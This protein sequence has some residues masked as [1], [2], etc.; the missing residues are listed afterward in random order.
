MTI[1]DIIFQ[2]LHFRNLTVKNRIFRSNISGR[3]DNY[4]GS[5]SQARIN[6]EEK[7][8]KGGVGAI[9]SSFVPVSI[10]GRILPNYA[11]IHHD[12][13]I[14]FWRKL[15]E[16]L[17]EY[18]C[19]YI[20]QLSHSGRQQDYGGIENL[21]KKALSST[22]KT[23]SFHG[24]VCQAMTKAEIDEA[25]QEFADGA[26]RARQAGLD[27]V[28][29]HGANGYLITQFLSSGINDRKDEYGGSLENRARFLMEIIAAV[30]RE[31]G[32]D[33]HFQVKI[34]AVD[35]NNAVIPWE[36]KGNTLED[37][38]Q[39]CKWMEQAGVDAIHV[40]TGSLFPHP[41]NP[42]GGFPSDE[43][44]RTYDTIV[45]SGVYTFRNYI[46]LRY[47][48]LRTI[49]RLL[50]NRTKGKVI[51]GVNV[52]NARAIKNA[53]NIPVICTGGFQTASY[54]RRVINE[55]ACDAVSIARSLVANNDL[56]QIFASGK[57]R[58][59]KPCTY[60]NK[61]LVNVLENPLGCYELSRF[62]GDYDRMMEQVMS[63]FYPTGFEE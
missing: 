1:N 32:D 55:G 10:R 5:G 61:C 7:F 42:I 56:V 34:S 29:L 60:C 24:F 22:S 19:K 8:A 47:P 46:L 48:P 54:I 30:R 39:V 31:V 13:T 36:K 45:S 33:F 50:W 53:V 26:R 4:D 38:I 2:P 52:E 15:G 3:F 28:E 51:E 17:H 9:C 27:G 16:K 18:D 25:V 37:T 59:D 57:D 63:V 12:K 35:Y 49:F 43:A 20:L 14:P 6:W 44:L 62:D 58:P 23:E 40:S 11:T 21:G 41:R